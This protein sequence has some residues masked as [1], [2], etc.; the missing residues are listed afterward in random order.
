MP[1]V[2]LS[3]FSRQKL[4]HEESTL[5]ASIE[6]PPCDSVTGSCYYHHCSSVL[7][8]TKKNLRSNQTHDGSEI[9]HNK[10]NLILKL[11]IKETK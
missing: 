11:Q 6:K 4:N 5:A 9:K 1:K 7:S 2:L 8:L 10:T 3:K